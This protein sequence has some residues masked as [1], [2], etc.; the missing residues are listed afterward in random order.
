MNETLTGLEQHE[1][2]YWQNFYF[3]VNYPFKKTCK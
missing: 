2:N 3:W 1:S